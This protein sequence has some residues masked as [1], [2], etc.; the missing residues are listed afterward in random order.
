[1]RRSSCY[2]ALLGIWFIFLF[3]RLYA[4]DRVFV[5]NIRG[6]IDKSSWHM[7][8]RGFFTAQEEE[9]SLIILRLNT[10]GGAVDMADSMRT[11]ILNSRVPV[12]AFVDNQAASAGALISLACDS[13]YMREGASIGAA[14]VVGGTGEAMPDKYQSFMRSIMRSTAQAKGRCWRRSTRGDSMFVYRR[15]P[16]LAESMVDPDVVIPGVVDSGKVLTLTAHEAE[17]LGMCDGIAE[18]VQGILGRNDMENATVDVFTPTRTD[19]FLAFMISPWVSAILI[20]LM[21]GGIYFELQTPGVGFPLLVALL[22][23]VAFLAP[24]Y[25]EGLVQHIDVLL[26]VAGVIL[27]L[28]EIFVIPG[29]GIAGILGILALIAG[30]ALSM[31]DNTIVFSWQPGALGMILVALA[32]V[33]GSLTIS[34]ICCLI[35]SAWLLTNPRIPALAL[36]SNLQTE[37]GYV[38]VEVP[39]DILIGKR[40]EAITV[41][42]PGGKVRIEGEV[43]DAIATLGMLDKGTLVV[44][45]RIETSQIYVRPDRA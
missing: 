26:F 38:G 10:Y 37:D 1:M 22:A 17:Q 29:F 19:V 9:A 25:V 27:I 34:V 5:I 4:G 21:I 41:L 2:F 44:V 42:R 7:L 3:P 6:A 45:E 13:I 30:L 43:Y 18:S 16:Q 24:Y 32:T 8:Q 28:L 40:G 36:R 23:G 31:V 14:T 33:L 20:M 39:E 15:S 35:L 12:W 11:A